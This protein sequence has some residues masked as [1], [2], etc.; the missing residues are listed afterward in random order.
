MTTT[1]AGRPGREAHEFSTS[2]TATP[3]AIRLLRDLTRVQLRAWDLPWLVD[4]ARLVVSELGT[5]ALAAAPGAVIEF[6]LFTEPEALVVE[7]WDPCL[8]APVRRTA[9]EEDTGGRGLE[10]VESLAEAWGARFPGKGGKTVWARL[11]STARE[12][13]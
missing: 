5:N 10:I 8:A 12:P 11:P 6:R 4:D 7:L 13:R 2:L 1:T 9:R 3:A